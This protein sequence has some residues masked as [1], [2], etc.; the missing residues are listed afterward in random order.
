MSEPSLEEK[1]ML[2]VAGKIFEVSDAKDHRDL[3][4]T[5]SWKAERF[6][7]VCMSLSPLVLQHTAESICG[8]LLKIFKGPLVFDYHKYQES[9]DECYGGALMAALSS[10]TPE[11]V[12]TAMAKFLLSDHAKTHQYVMS[13]DM[14]D[15]FDASFEAGTR[16]NRRADGCVHTDEVLQVFLKYRAMLRIFVRQATRASDWEA[17]AALIRLAPEETQFIVGLV[18]ENCGEF[19]V[20]M[21]ELNGQLVMKNSQYAILIRQALIKGNS[22]MA[23]YD[24]SRNQ[25]CLP[26]IIKQLKQSHATSEQITKPLAEFVSRARAD[27]FDLSPVIIDLKY[28]AEYAL[29]HVGETVPVE[30][31][32]A[33]CHREAAEQTNAV[34]SGLLGSFTPQEI[35]ATADADRYF[36]FLAGQFGAKAYMQYIK[37]RSVKTRLAGHG[38]NI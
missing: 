18:A 23:H 9:T 10:A 22:A 25:A 28:T 15:R 1:V 32:I 12:D 16:I 19:G 37:D 6:D 5:S 35:A 31:Q 34:E 7:A 17:C 21:P 2:A 38:L 4:W 11:T 24:K 20:L 3:G 27:G 8:V 30:D 13:T 26:T 36:E 14:T 29:D 33:Y